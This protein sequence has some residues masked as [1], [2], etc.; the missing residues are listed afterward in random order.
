M[1]IKK[2]NNNHGFSLIEVLVAAGLM[3]LVSTGLVS[4]VTTM[5]K[6]Q[7][8]QFRTAALRE[9]KTRIQYLVSD[10]NSWSRTLQ[11]NGA[12]NT[13]SMWCINQ[14]TNCTPGVY[15]LKLY[16]SFGNLF[17]NAPTYTL[18]SPG[19]PAASNGFTDK[20]SPCTTFNGNANAGLESCPI[21][22]KIVW[23]PVCISAVNCKNP[24]IKVTARMIYNTS[25]SAQ[26]ASLSQGNI[27]GSGSWTDDSV[28]VNTGKYDIVLKRS[29]TTINKSFTIAI[30]NVSGAATPGGPCSTTVALP[31]ERGATGPSWTTADDNFTLVSVTALSS[32]IAIKAGTYS[33]KI[34]ALGY[35]VDNFSIKLI[36]V[37]PSPGDVLGSEASGNAP[38]KLQAAAI[39]NPIL[40]LTADS[41]FKLVQYCQRVDPGSPNFAMGLPAGPYT[42]A[43]VY[44]SMT[45]TQTN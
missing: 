24:L 38:D 15:D 12:T 18:N 45:C 22:Y 16:D 28:A 6:E 4:M 40:S 17:L 35:S 30:T 5:G 25:N 3:A 8:N 31:T 13:D 23:E 2:L 44:A 27:S 29:A 7:N 1:R 10:Q 41:T 32:L 11:L 14:K 43:S 33:C 42:Q 26:V 39:S 36:E 34:V 20:G 37:A 9:L 19:W 21:T